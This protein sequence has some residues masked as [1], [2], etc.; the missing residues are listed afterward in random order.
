MLEND[1]SPEAVGKR[2]RRLRQIAGLKRKQMAELA[3]VGETSISVWEHGKSNFELSQRSINKILDAVKKVG[4]FCS[5]DWLRKGVGVPPKIMPNDNSEKII[6][7]IKQGHFEKEITLTLE[8]EIQLFASLHSSNVILKVEH[9]GM[10]P[11]IKSGDY[12]GGTWYS[13]FDDNQFEQNIACI[14]QINGK[15]D[16]RN[17]RKGT[18]PDLYTI[19]YLTYST[20]LTAPFE[21]R[22][23]PVQKIAQLKRL[24]RK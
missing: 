19:S 2:L 15:L 14:V 6:N 13:N 10:L 24:W 21:I 3:E 20:G 5:E 18:K 8:E 9:D 22:D 4:I 11:I 7:F 16:L 1:E 17:I 23:I 12:I